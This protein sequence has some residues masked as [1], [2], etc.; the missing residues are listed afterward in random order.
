[1]RELRGV[2]THE[3]VEQALLMA[4]GFHQGCARFAADNRIDLLDG[5]FFL[6]ILER[7]PADANRRLLELAT[8]G[9]WTTPT[10]PGCGTKMIARDS[11]RGPSGV[12]QPT[13]VP[14]NAADAGTARRWKRQLMLQGVDRRS[15]RSSRDRIENGRSWFGFAIG[16]PGPCFNASVIHTGDVETWWHPQ[17]RDRG[18][19]TRWR[20]Q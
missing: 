20:S 1:M 5:E 17:G 15:N 8:E 13:E 4:P 19:G 7:L 18:G 14:R 2:M 9:D 12:A 3:K 11:K 6:T 16:R 10:C